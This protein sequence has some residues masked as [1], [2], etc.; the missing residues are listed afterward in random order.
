VVDILNLID[1]ARIV[2]LS[3][4]QLSVPS[5]AH[6]C[7][8][9]ASVG[10]AARRYRS[11]AAWPVLGSS[12]CERCH[13]VSW[14]RK[15]N[16]DLFARWQQ[17]FDLLRSLLQQLVWFLPTQCYASMGASYGPVSVSVC[18]KSV[19]C[20]NGWTNLAGF[21]HGSFLWPILHCVIRKFVYLKT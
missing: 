2:C 4:I 15:L 20:W 8:G 10:L 11:I 3:S 12:S 17:C 9:F 18:H 21:W 1:T 13:V 16:T 19:F 7:G 5:A 14:C 6:R